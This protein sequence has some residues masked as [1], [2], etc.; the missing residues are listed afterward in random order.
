MNPLN[1]SISCYTCL[2]CENITIY[3]I[4]KGVGRCITTHSSGIISKFCEPTYNQLDRE[5]TVDRCSTNRCNR[6]TKLS[7][8]RHVIIVLFVCIGISKYIL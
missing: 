7:I 4:I 5:Y 2:D 3:V 8:H 1:N 6:M